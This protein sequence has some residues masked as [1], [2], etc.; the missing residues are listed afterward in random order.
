ML[1]RAHARSLPKAGNAEEEYEDAF[2][3]ATG[4]EYTRGLRFAVA[5]GATETSFS[6]LWA[7]QL[8]EAYGRGRLG[9]RR[10][11]DAI[12]RLRCAW[13]GEVGHRPLPWYAEEKLRQGAYAAFL[14]LS[15]SQVRDGTIRWSASA[16]GDCCLFQISGD[17]LVECFPLTTSSEFSNR[18]RLVGSVRP[19]GGDEIPPLRGRGGALPGDRFLLM[20]DAL[21]CWFLRRAE[22]GGRPWEDVAEGV[23]Q[24]FGAWIGGLRSTGV[25]RNDDVTLLALAVE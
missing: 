1:I 25:L 12:A 16:V 8:V 11:H 10:W 18:P 19:A 4:S 5:D 13:H 7:R 17:G 14:G 21:A 9:I 24:D 15:F 3:P 2:W 22:D 23:C 20:S 6:G